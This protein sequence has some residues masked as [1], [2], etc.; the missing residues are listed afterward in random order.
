MPIQHSILLDS[1]KAGMRQA[2]GAC[3]KLTA[4][5]RT[6]IPSS[7]HKSPYLQQVPRAAGA[8]L[9]LGPGRLQ[10]AQHR[11]GRGHQ[12]RARGAQEALHVGYGDNDNDDDNEDDDDDASGGIIL[13]V[14]G[15]AMCLGVLLWWMV[16][17][18]IIRQ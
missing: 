9:P 17:K 1:V 10:R 3:N 5:L 4:L 6:L 13:L 2:I 16:T 7:P 15:A 12:V 8:A 18:K 11:D 14:V